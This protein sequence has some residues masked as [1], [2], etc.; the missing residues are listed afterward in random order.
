M[1]STNDKGVA[2]SR[3]Y[4]EGEFKDGERPTGKDFADL[5]ASSINLEDDGVTVVREKAPSVDVTCIQF[6]NPIEV[7]LADNFTHVEEDKERV[8]LGNGIFY[9]K[10]DG[11]DPANDPSSTTFAHKKLVGE[12]DFALRQEKA[13]KVTLNAPDMQTVEISNAGV[14]KVTVNGDQV[15]IKDAD[16][17]TKV[18]LDLTGNL[19][20]NNL[21]GGTAS[22]VTL[23]ASGSEVDLAV[24]GDAAVSGNANVDGDATIGGNANIDGDASFSGD[25]IIGSTADDGL[26]LTSTNSNGTAEWQAPVWKKEP[27]TSPTSASTELNIGINLGGTSPTSNFQVAGS[28]LLTGTTEVSGDGTATTPVLKVTDTDTANGIAL[29]V[30]GKTSLNGSFQLENGGEGANKVLTSDSSGEATWEDPAWEKATAGTLTT[31]K[32][33]RLVGINLAAGTNPT[34]NLQVTGETR[35]DNGGSGTTLEIIGELIIDDG[36]TGHVGGEVLTRGANNRAT[37]QNSPLAQWDEVNSD[38]TY[39]DGNVGVG[40]PSGGT[41]QAQFVVQGDTLLSNPLGTALT[42][43]GELKYNHGLL[44][45][46]HILETNL[47]NSAEWRAPVWTKDD[48]SAPTLITTNLLVGIGVSQPSKNLEVTGETFLSGNIGNTL[49]VNGSTHTFKGIY[50]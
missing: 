9:N 16:D 4:L 3:V 39:D 15:I 22:Q 32:T 46:G 11:M 6:A 37:W 47:D 30:I 26:V 19:T 10:L 13:G 5:I 25:V 41:L 44:G 14:A 18:N 50:H 17:L 21:A 38:L 35:L 43:D 45:D 20:V 29:E 48:K 8:V 7:T 31:A 12:N 27:L 2:Q 33:S 42:I 49:E 1:A 34:K 36:G 23:G 40:I 24:N 28:S